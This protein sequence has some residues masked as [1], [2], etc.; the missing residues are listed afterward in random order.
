MRCLGALTC[1]RSPRQ[2]DR[3]RPPRYSSFYWLLSTD[4][5]ERSGAAL[6]LEEGL[7]EEARRVGFDLAGIAPATGRRVRS[8]GN[9]LD[10]GYAGEMAYLHQQAEATPSAVDLPHRSLRHHGRPE[11]QA[12][13]GAAAG[14]VPGAGGPLC[15]RAGL[16]PRHPRTAATRRRWLRQRPEAWGRSWSTRRRCWRRL[17]PPRRPRL[18]RQ[19]H[20]AAAPAARGGWFVLGGLLVDVKLRPTTRS[21]PAACP[22]H[23]TACLDAC[24]TDAFVAPFRLDATMYQLPDHRAEIVA[25][26]TAASTIGDWLFGCDVCQDVCPWNRKALRV[27]RCWR[28]GPTLQAVNAFKL[29]I[30]LDDDA[31][32]RPVRGTTTPRPGRRVVLRNA[33]LVLGNTGDD[34]ALPALEQATA[35]AEPL[36]AEA[37]AWAIERIR[38]RVSR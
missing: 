19:E 13:R 3:R 26:R 14:G 22:G 32:P 1:S 7:I 24:P 31:F 18:V 21:R 36:L 25:P 11:L 9:W 20:H 23:A 16:P 17:R 12:G 8:T 5:C 6:L 15:P 34:R 38:E 35:D 4:Y 28:R 29:R 10:Q 37:A 2:Q 33:A 30:G 27:V